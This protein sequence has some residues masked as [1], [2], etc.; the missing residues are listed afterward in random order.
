M[1]IKTLASI[2]L[3]AVVGT[4]LSSA[5][6]SG[7]A[8]TAP[9]S[10]QVGARYGQLPLTFEANRGQTAGQV[11]FLSRGKG[12]T[13]FLTTGGMV[14]TLR[15]S[16][17]VTTSKAANQHS[18][19]SGQT[20]S[21]TLQFQ[22][23]GANK[24]P[25][26]VGE[27][28]QLGKV[29]Y[30][31]GNDPSQWHTNLPTYAQVRYKNVYPGIDLIYYGNHQ[32]LEY[33]FAVAPG[34]DPRKIQFQ[35]GGA[36]HIQVDAEGN[37]I[38]NTNNGELHFKT[39]IVYQESNGQRV[40]VEG[41]YILKDSTHV[42]FQV[43]TYDSSKSLVIDPVLVYSTY[44]GGS[45]TDQPS[46]IAVDSTGSVY[47]A[48]YTDSANF[49]LST[50][51][52]LPTNT[53]HVF[54]AKLDASGSNLVYADYIG[55]NN[56]D[57]GIALV[58]DNANNVYVTGSTQS[59]NFPLVKPFQS[60]QPGPYSGF[61]TKVSADGSALLYSTYLGGSTLDQPTSIAIDGLGEAF[62]AGYTMSQNF[63]VANAYQ[64]TAPANQGGMFGSYGFLTKFST[65]GSSLV[66]STYLGGNSNV[67]QD[68]GTPCLPA[69]YNAVS[70]LT[71]DS[72]GNVY[73]TG[74][75][76]TYNFPVTTGAYQTTNSTPQD[77]S[78][79]FLSKFS[80]A[81]SLD[82]STY[83]YGSSGN[84]VGIGAIAVDATG[85]A[86]IAGSAQSDGTF[87]ITSTS[88][89][90]PGANG[91]GCSYAFVTKFDP[92]GSTLMYS[93]FLGA[94][95][96]ANPQAIVLDASGDAYVLAAASSGLLQTNNAIEAYTGKSDLLLVEIDPAAS[97]QLFST[98]LGGSGN[99]SPSGLALDANGNI[100]VTGSTDSADLPTTQGAF[101]TVLGGGTD[102]F[103]MKIGMASAASVSLS[104]GSL[105]YASLPVGS[106]S[107]PQTVL[108]RNMG[109]SALS[110]S[111]ITASGDF[112]EIDNCSPGVAA[113][114]SCMIS[115][116]FTPTAAGSRSGSIVIQDNA[117]GSTQSIALSGIGTAASVTLTP[118]NL[119][120][121]SVTVGSSSAA[122]AVTLTNSGNAP[123]SIS[124]VQASGD[125]AQTNNCPANLA[126][127]SS[128]TINVVFSPTAS[129]T[130]NGTLTLT[131][132]ALSGSQTVSLTG[133]ASVS[134]FSLSSSVDD[135]TVKAGATAT[136]AL[137][138]APV[139]GS[140]TKA[141][142][143]S[144]SGL[145]GGAT[146]SFSPATVTPG[147]KSTAVTLT[148]STA[149]PTAEMASAL[150]TPNRPA[151]AVLIQI[152]GLGLFGMVVAGSRKRSKRVMIFILLALLV[153]GMLCMSGCAGGTGIAP[154][155][156]S[157]T[158]YNVT[159]TG[160][161]GALQHSLPLT[162][163]VQ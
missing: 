9:R 93:T 127:N 58:L 107:Q 66:Y 118:A 32:Q 26:V 104:P 15:P 40:P 84:P 60:Q 111:S 12:Y 101:Q 130:R 77:A 56:Q 99:D 144:C 36:S 68:C 143:F 34:A 152:Q 160:T 142:S 75:T 136:F 71:V 52:S 29:N 72:N 126:A 25:A 138:V 92:T 61:L 123:L 153:V 119:S 158:T 86:Y 17:V 78:I 135:A 132:S 21:T 80:S 43:A 35:I 42:G 117:T 131:D 140:F 19:V 76:N 91:F 24:N 54:V 154:P 90:D 10:E 47:V 73:V 146:C 97:T 125:F 95:N 110:I 148:I 120:F 49:P 116:T 124:N 112:S 122:Q 14:L 27:N 81:G 129:G 39:P 5:Q 62:I 151:T 33:D 59:S 89:C 149:A 109:D 161:S 88:I 4:T 102:A 67:A 65:D 103:V 44:L 63:P 128:C 134:D 70:A 115:V 7:A 79:G 55:G 37:L 6:Q 155:S 38:L 98:Y 150:P 11:K 141:V 51:G 157:G 147:T 31:F 87:P 1:R 106:S 2:L 162:L 74:T 64:T 22:L 105:Q 163:T 113:A 46:G 133:S 20:A 137:T 30:F 100:Y 45:G 139:S 145:P 3:T 82:Y 23:L 48:G 57:Y 8:Q 94:N 41:G 114:S 83:F 156:G 13:A 159:V 53:N 69:P 108:L 18:S 16:R 96:Y 85:S 121:S 28:L 50:L